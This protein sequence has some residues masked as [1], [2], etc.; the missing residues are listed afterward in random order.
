MIKTILELLAII[1]IT[2][3]VLLAVDSRKQL[4]IKNLILNFIGGYF[5]EKDRFSF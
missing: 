3:V 2:I 5:D 4:F 1:I